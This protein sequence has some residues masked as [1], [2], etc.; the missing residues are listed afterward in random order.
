VA[1]ACTVLAITAPMT[2]AQ[3]LIRDAEIER[4]LHSI[5]APIL[6]A[7]GL[8]RTSVTIYIV[9]D[10]ELNAFVAGGRNI[11]INSGLLRRLDSVQEIQ[12]ILA[13]ETGH[14]TG[15]HLAPA[16]EVARGLS[17]AAALGMLLAVAAG[18]S[19]NGD[20]ATAIAL[21]SQGAVQNSLLAFSRAQEAA[22]DQASVRFMAGAGADAQAILEVLD[23]FR[24]QEA[25]SGRNRD[26]Y[27]MTHPLFSRRYSLL[28][29]AVGNAP[30][31]KA[32]T[33][34]LGYQHARLVAKFEGFQRNPKQV[35]RDIP[36]GDNSEF[37]TLKRAIAYHR[38]PD[39]KRATEAIEALIRAH[40]DDAYY[41]ELRGQF[42]LE[43]RQPA[44]AVNAYRKAV[45]LAPKEPL[46]RAG[47]GRALLA[48][49]SKTANREA[50]KVL[51]GARRADAAD[52]RMLRDLALAYARAG[53]PAQ[54]SL[55]TAE[56]YMLRGDFKDAALHA[57]R[58]AGR[59]SE[60][61]AGWLH[62]QDILQ[63]A[64]R[65]K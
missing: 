10:R 8:S 5:A 41:H 43:N 25:L 55:I 58:A 33:A 29:E 2:Q 64:G 44:A 23:L 52:S 21:T 35:L 60:G 48:V 46:I 47:L 12:A 24:G 57:K 3:S 34:A 22:A 27:T 14:I 19:G 30:P 7:A 62:A 63:Q 59:F 39:R 38:L 11:F 9:N 26:P 54:A 56:R 40:P 6:R 17:G 53:Q 28:E 37:A 31:G 13:H 36:K 51:R 42:R 18:A 4:T 49:G 15:G 32:P 20:A 61:S 45:S 1:L 50:L 16:A 65:V